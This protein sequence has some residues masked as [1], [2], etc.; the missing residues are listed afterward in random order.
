MLGE[1]VQAPGDDGPAF[2][3][4]VDAARCGMAVDTG[5]N[6]DAFIDEITDSA[7]GNHE[8]IGDFLQK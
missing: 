5:G 7:C 3:A 4:E 1:E 2:D 6:E 8:G